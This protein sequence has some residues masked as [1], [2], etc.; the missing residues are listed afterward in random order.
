W[1]LNVQRALPG[2]I[3]VEAAY[4]GSAGVGLLSGATDINQLSP[5]A[6][7]IARQ[8][9]VGPN[10]ALT[11]IGNLAVANPFL[12]LPVDQRPP[13]TSPILGRPTVTV[14]QLLRPFPQFGNV[15]SYSQNEAHSSYHSFQLTVSRRAGEGLTFSPAYSLPK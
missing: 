1:N 14:A 15:V 3:T 8:V 12:T 9:V 13:T 2:G 4:A 5:E 7:A 6:L 11:P 10:G